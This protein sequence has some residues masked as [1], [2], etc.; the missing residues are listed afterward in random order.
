[1]PQP[2]LLRWNRVAIL[3]V[4]TDCVAILIGLESAYW[5][6]FK[7]GWL[8][9]L[10]PRTPTFAL[11]SL[12]ALLPFWIAVLAA[13]GL[14]KRRNL[15]SGLREYGYVLGASGSAVLI[16]V[17]LTYL[18]QVVDLSRGFLLLAL[19]GMTS[20]LCLGRFVV[21]RVI[22]FAARRRRPLDSVLVIGANQQAVAIAQMLAQSPSAA[23][24]VAGFLSEYVTVGRVVTDGLRV[25]GEPL[26]LDRVA[27]EVGATRA[28]VVESDLSWESLQHIV[29]HMHRQDSID[30]C[31][32]PGLFDLHATP[33]EAVKL[34]PV[35][36][37]SPHPTRI[38]GFEALVKRGFDIVLGVT[39]LTAALPVIAVLMVS[40]A[41]GGH[42]FGLASRR[43]LARGGEIQLANF[44]YPKWAR[45]RHL[46]RLPELAAV[47]R[48][49]IS[50]IGPRPIQVERGAEYGR[51]LSLIESAKP[52]LVGP[53][54]LV[55]LARPSGIEDELAY[56]LFYLR[57]YSLWSDLQILLRV[58]RYL[59]GVRK[60][61]DDS[62]TGH[63]QTAPITIPLGDRAQII[64]GSETD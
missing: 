54:W 23:S 55:D 26:E 7:A 27:S 2:R 47:I 6:R 40:A 15:V 28:L 31:L 24:C 16:I 8:I 22:Y 11:M 48:G 5:L 19:G 50:L 39:A 42:G 44:S 49:T 64:P 37:L 20:L 10:E 45:Q 29:R 41:L 52:G 36:A 18:T 61:P 51:A 59:G 60:R 3:L 21:R 32:V 53:W 30:I 12:V 4:A 14:Y 38:V 35:L 34:G 46:S 56:D 25:L 13:A 33:M 63:T 57:N 17:V 9:G 58:V 43:F 62:T 1:M